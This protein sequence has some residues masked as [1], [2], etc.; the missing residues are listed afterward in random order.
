MDLTWGGGCTGGGSIGLDDRRI[1]LHAGLAFPNSYLE[2]RPAVEIMM[3]G[4]SHA[5]APN[6][7]VIPA[8]GTKAST[9]T[10]SHMYIHIYTHIHTY[11][12]AYICMYVSMYVCIYG[13][14]ASVRSGT[15]Q[16]K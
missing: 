2:L 3:E 4:T 9:H 5:T 13:R 15:P 11:V 8:P 6:I 7:S 14:P 12:Y 10:H 1:D 16:L